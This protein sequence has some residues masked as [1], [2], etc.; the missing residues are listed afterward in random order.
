MYEPC[1]LLG[2]LVNYNKFEFQNPYQLRLEDFVN[3]STIHKMT[4]GIGTILL[5]SRNAY[6]N[7][8]DDL[9]EGWTFASTLTY[10]GLGGLITTS[11]TAAAT[12]SEEDM[13][14]AFASM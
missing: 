12:L 10:F 6:L 1:T 2:L 4:N 3:D 14:I 11:R 9:T 7:I 13:K 5:S 8:Q